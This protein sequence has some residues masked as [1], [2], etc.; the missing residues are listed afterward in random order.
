MMFFS[1]TLDLTVSSV[2]VA[3][4]LFM[5][6]EVGTFNLFSLI[7]SSIIILAWRV[8]SSFNEVTKLYL[9]DTS[10]LRIDLNEPGILS[11]NSIIS[12]FVSTLMSIV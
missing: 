3:V 12:S 6:L 1:F 2:S 5:L 11:I 7:L 8:T 4:V 9:V 10:E